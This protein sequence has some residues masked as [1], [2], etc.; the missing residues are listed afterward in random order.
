[1]AKKTKKVSKKGNAKNAKV[2]KTDSKMIKKDFLKNTTFQKYI[3]AIAIVAVA[4]WTLGY[5]STPC[6]TAGAAVVTTDIGQNAVSQKVVDYLQSRLEISYPGIT[7]DL[8]SVS[9][10]EDIEGIYQ[11]NVDV[12]FQGQVQSVPYFATKDGN[13]L[14]TNLLDLNEPAPEVQQQPEDTQQQTGDTLAANQP[15]NP[16]ITT[17]YDSGE[18]I[19]TEEG[20]P[21]IRM[22]SSSSC[23]YCSWSKPIFENVTKEYMDAGK[24]ISY[25]WEDNMNTLSGNDEPITEDERSIYLTYNPRG[26]IPTFV[27]GCKYYRI[28][29]PHSNSQNGEALEEAELRAVIEDLLS[30]T[31]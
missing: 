22:F 19:C 4:A 3:A 25:H 15:S 8:D 11:V 14:F 21:V 10:H 9:E 7:V 23:P 1:M 13:T 12:S 18:E 26:T 2:Q 28:G 27:F 31:E 20:K 30:Q 17:F 5:F 29:A 24:I 6:A 16:E